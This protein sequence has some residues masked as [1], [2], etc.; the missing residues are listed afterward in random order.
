MHRIGIIGY[1]GFGRFLHR[2]WSN[3]PGIAVHAVSDEHQPENLAGATFYRD[4]R[5]LIADP[6]VDI[7]SIAT[8]PH[9][10]TAMACAAM[11]AGKHV[12]IEKPLATTL[13]DARRIIETRDRTGR[14]A[15]VDYVLRFN[16]IVEALEAW[17]RNGWFGALRRMTV[18]NY[19]QDETLPPTH[20]FWDERQSGGILVEHAVH[21]IDF[22]NACA[23]GTPQHVDGVSVRRTPQQEDRM[24]LTMVYDDGLVA[25]QY[26][27][28]AR[29]RFFERTSMRLVYDLAEV[30][31]EGWMPLSGRVRAMTNPHSRDHLFRLPGFRVADEQRLL[32]DRAGTV[33]VGGVEYEADAVV[34]GS[35]AMA[36]PKDEVYGAAVCTVMADLVRA[37]GDPEHSLRVPLEAGVASL[38]VAVEATRS[39][40]E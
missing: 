21:F 27:E 12:L 36:D 37:I 34:N 32:R 6:E 7:V 29:P 24:L 31:V 2:A 28:F 25:T 17:S 15:S 18:E 40:R 14:V 3:M 8:P 16:P 1:G 11:E 20:W 23:G 10:H 33:R 39:A 38:S 13:E 4:W 19:A 35:F 9:A 22:T 5:D 30:E 26:H